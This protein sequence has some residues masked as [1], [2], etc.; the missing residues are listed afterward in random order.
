MPPPAIGRRTF[1]LSLAA[2]GLGVPAALSANNPL[3]RARAIVTGIR[4]ETRIPGLRLCL[5]QVL[6]RVSGDPRLENHPL[7]AGLARKPEDAVVQI[8]FRDLY[9]FRKIKDEQGTRDRPHEMTV[10]YGPTK[11]DAM[12]ER[13][14]SKPWLGERPRPVVFLAVRHVGSSFI[15]TTTNEI[16]EL[17]RQSLEAAAWRFALQV[18]LPSE[19]LIAQAGLAFETLP[20]TPLTALQSLVQTSVGETPLLGSLV[21]DRELL[22]WRSQWRIAYRGTEY[23]W[24]AR[25]GNFDLAFRHAIGGAARIFSGNGAPG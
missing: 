10:E 25:G 23:V 1:A 14:G 15:L 3:Y 9:A 22:G 12:L 7:V 2:L 4:D 20:E 8:S 24:T 6:V 19:R 5:P 21:W 13:L 11:I 16:G 17:Q 18:K